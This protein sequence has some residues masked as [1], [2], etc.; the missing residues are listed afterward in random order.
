[1]QQ[2]IG[3]LV[4]STSVGVERWVSQICK[5]FAIE[6]A[7]PIARASLPEVMSGPAIAPSQSGELT[8]AA[9][10][11][12]DAGVGAVVWSGSSADL[13]GA[14]HGRAMARWVEEV[15]GVRAS[16][17]TLGQ[18]DLLSRRDIVSMAL[19]S[20]GNEQTAGR[21]AD[22]YL[23]AGFKISSVTALGLTTAREAAELPVS[24]VRR[25][26]LDADSLDAQCIVVAGTELPVA[27][28][29]ALV[30]RELGKPVYDGAR[31]A[32]RTGLELL[33]LS[34]TAPE[35]GEM[36]GVPHAAG[37]CCDTH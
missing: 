4:P 15:T 13:H 27:P 2:R 1:M 17:V 16:T 31:V 26:L 25:L 21:L 23:A 19:V 35:W 6:V 20:A 12:A 32:I 11:L 24:R 22:T 28:V 36:F 18:I 30:E 37:V 14:A 8:R 33:G 9:S 7:H 5:P 10:Q 3:H 29:A 34:V